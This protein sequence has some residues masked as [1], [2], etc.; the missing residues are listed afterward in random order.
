MKTFEKFPSASL[1]GN[2][3]ARCKRKINEAKIDLFLF[4]LRKSNEAENWSSIFESEVYEKEKLKI[5]RRRFKTSASFLS[6]MFIRETKLIRIKS[7]RKC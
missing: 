7:L 5:D 4:S 3:L 2:D 6:Q 1:N